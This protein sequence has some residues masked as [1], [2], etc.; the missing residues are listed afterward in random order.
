MAA[1]CALIIDTAGRR[2]QAATRGHDVSIPLLFNQMQPNFFGA[3]HA[4]EN[5][6]TAGAFIGDVRRG[7]SCNCSTYSLTPHCNGTHT[8]CVGHIVEERISVRDVADE[9]FSTALLVS[10]APVAA[11]A[12]CEA[13]GP[14]PHSGDRLITQALLEAA[15]AGENL[16]DYPALVIRTLPNGPAKRFRNYGA[17][18]AP[19][20]FSAEA[21]RW[22]VQH[23]VRRL[24]VDLP[25]VDRS[26]DEGRLTAHRIFW[27]LLPGEK[28]VA[29]ATRG[30]AT[31]TELAYIENQIPDGRYLLNLQ[32]APF[33][34][35]A[36]P[37]RPILLPLSPI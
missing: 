15:V 21:M 2:W 9:H 3:A 24:V 10:T 29:K 28:S 32:V 18:E 30:N 35:D 16:S 25:S 4:A 5:T 6:F 17:S 8:E 11:S 1:D 22:I 26:N 23:D 19:P 7:A 20:Y 34:A 27:G 31:I 33:A 36:A 37:S 12:T 13:S 14:N